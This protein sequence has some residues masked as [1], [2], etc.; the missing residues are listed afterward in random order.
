[1]T[2]KNKAALLGMFLTA[3]A[4]NAQAGV[5]DTVTVAGSSVL[6]SVLSNKM[7]IA[8]TAGATAGAVGIVK[9][10]RDAYRAG[11]EIVIPVELLEKTVLTEEEMARLVVYQQQLIALADL[12]VKV[13][14]SAT[15]FVACGGCALTKAAA[16]SGLG[17]T[18]TGCTAL[19]GVGASAL[20]Y[21]P[22]IGSTVKEVASAAPAVPAVPAATS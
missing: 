14:M 18:K 19:Y 17:W 10:L 15:A 1:M 16:F 2:S 9:Y 4:F 12:R 6:S 20:S 22:F 3:T 7:N 11:K 13:W 8:W 21:V 5:V